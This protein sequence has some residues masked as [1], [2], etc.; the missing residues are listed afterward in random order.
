MPYSDPEKAKECKRKYYERNRQLV[1][2]RSAAW[3]KANPEKAKTAQAKNRKNPKVK[4]QKI[5]YYQTNK[6]KFSIKAKEWRKNNAEKLQQYEQARYLSR[7]DEQA[8][9]SKGYREK[10]RESLRVKQS[11][12]LRGYYAT[13]PEYVAMHRLRTRM[14]C[15]LRGVGSKSART[16]EL[17]GCTGQELVTHLE[18]K[19]KLGMSWENRHLW[20]ID[21]IKPCKLFDLTDPIQQRACF[22]FSNLQPLWEIENRR[23]GAKYVE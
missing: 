13:R 4:A 15:A 2:E 11:A 3:A 22:H 18:G 8:E 17:L 9:Y 20:H 5:Q 12:K 7:K 1:I 6:E 10:N 14:N 19:F 23:K 21:H 16:M